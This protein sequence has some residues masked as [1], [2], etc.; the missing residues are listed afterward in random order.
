MPSATDEIET[1]LQFQ[2]KDRCPKCHN[3][4]QLATIEPHPTKQDIALH[5]FNCIDCGPVMVKVHSLKKI[6]RAA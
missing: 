4:V 1:V 6:E 5:Y 3:P 2:I